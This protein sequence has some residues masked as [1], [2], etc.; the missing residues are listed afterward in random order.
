MNIKE[1]LH[2]VEW[3]VIILPFDLRLVEGNLKRYTI[4]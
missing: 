1:T 3:Q 2:E 4:L